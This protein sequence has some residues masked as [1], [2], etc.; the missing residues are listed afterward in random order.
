MIIKHPYAQVFQSAH[1][2]VFY[3]DNDSKSGLWAL[4]TQT[5][6]LSSQQINKHHTIRGGDVLW[7]PLCEMES[8]QFSVGN[9]KKQSGAP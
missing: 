9:W 4:L 7:F 5:R 6:R 2:F 8:M 3:D 1:M